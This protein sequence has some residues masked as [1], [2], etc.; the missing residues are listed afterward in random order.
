MV[1]T[2]PIEVVF[3]ILDRFAVPLH[4]ETPTLDSAP[5]ATCSLVCH[6]WSGHSQRLLFRRVR[7]EGPFVVRSSQTQQGSLMARFSQTRM[8]SFLSA[9][10]PATQ[11]GRS[12]AASVQSLR[13]RPRH[14]FGHLASDAA[15]QLATALLRA[16]NLRELDVPITA[17]AFDETIFSDLMSAMPRITVL[18]INLGSLISLN[19]AVIFD[20]DTAMNRLCA[21]MQTC[22]LLRIS[23]YN[24]GRIPTFPLGPALPLLSADIDAGQVH[25][26]F[27]CLASLNPGNDP[28]ETLQILRLRGTPTPASWRNILTAYGLHLRSLSVKSLPI[29]P[30]APSDL[31]GCTRLERFEIGTFPSAKDLSAIPRTIKALSIQGGYDIMASGMHF[32]ALDPLLQ[33]VETFPY[34]KSITWILFKGHPQFHVLEEKCKSRDIAIR[35]AE[36]VYVRSHLISFSRYSQCHNLPQ[37]NDDDIELELRWQYLCSNKEAQQNLSL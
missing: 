10:D 34:L 31:L 15:H 19:P 28:N 37:L 18:F 17:C 13:F 11:K 16:H 4:F 27:P 29:D 20:S 14:L 22:R 6:A 8:A 25:D 32:L 1:L 23:S 5:L 2:L 35:T 36:I 7:I 3:D 26:P 9:I 12:L 24:T 21:L 30:N 33:A